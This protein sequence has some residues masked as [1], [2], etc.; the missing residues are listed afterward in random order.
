MD[1][2]IYFKPSERFGGTRPEWPANSI[3]DSLVSHTKKGFPSLE[4]AQIALFGVL[5][6]PG[7]ARPRACVHAPDAIRDELFQL[8]MPNGNLQILDLGDL[9]G[10][11]RTFGWFVL[12]CDGHDIGALAAAIVSAKAQSGLPGAMPSMIIMDTIKGKGADFAEG[13]LTNHNMNVDRATADKAIA[14]LYGEK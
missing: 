9:E 3:G 13:L 6:D 5:D 7:H 8:Y 12:R 10:K 11:W 14:A 1:I 2:S 4:G